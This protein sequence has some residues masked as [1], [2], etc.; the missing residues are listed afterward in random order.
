[1]NKPI[2]ELWINLFLSKL[3]ASTMNGSEDRA[4]DFRFHLQAILELVFSEVSDLYYIND[5][6]GRLIKLILI[7]QNLLL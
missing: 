3:Q 2:T 1:M 4:C 7:I 5:C 6:F